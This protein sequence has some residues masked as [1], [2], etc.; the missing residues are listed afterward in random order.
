VRER[1]LRLIFL[2]RSPRTRMSSSRIHCEEVEREA[3]NYPGLKEAGDYVLVFS[4]RRR[5]KD[6]RER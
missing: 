4:A 2:S 3:S 1:G 6:S 5:E